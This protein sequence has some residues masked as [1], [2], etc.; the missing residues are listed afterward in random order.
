LEAKKNLAARAEVDCK[1]ALKK[2]LVVRLAAAGSAKATFVNDT[3]KPLVKYQPQLWMLLPPGPHPVPKT[4][5]RGTG[6]NQRRAAERA[7]A[8]A[9]ASGRLPGQGMNPPD[10]IWWGKVDP[11]HYEKGPLTDAQG[12]AT[13][14]NLIP[15]ATYRLW[16]QPGKVKDFK[17]EAGKTLDLDMIVIREPAKPAKPQPPR[18]VPPPIKVKTRITKP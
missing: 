7:L 15:G 6:L 8:F 2:P 9:L 17:V 10:R 1:E 12:S 4:L 13:L 5:E 18:K 16:Q 14:P 3:G 11:L